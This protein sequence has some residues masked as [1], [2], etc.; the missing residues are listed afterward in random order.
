M[1]HAEAH[2]KLM[3]ICNASLQSYFHKHFSGQKVQQKQE[4]PLK[5]IT[6]HKVGLINAQRTKSME[7]ILAHLYL[8]EW[9]NRANKRV[10]G[11][12]GSEVGWWR[13][14]GGALGLEGKGIVPPPRTLASGVGGGRSRT[15]RCQDPQARDLLTGAC[16]P[17]GY[18]DGPL[19]SHLPLKY[20][21][22]NSQE[23]VHRPAGVSHFRENLFT[24]Q[25]LSGPRITS[26]IHIIALIVKE[27]AS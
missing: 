13:S 2:K 6:Q 27:N 25:H 24:H 23:P 11:S 10:S 21:F 26:S 17:G 20:A 8:C 4:K 18:P 16:A 19:S 1:P 5:T 14:Q 9:N 12:T 22:T 3:Y 7:L 15:V